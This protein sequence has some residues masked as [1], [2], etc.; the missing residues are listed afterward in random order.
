MEVVVSGN[1]RDTNRMQTPVQREY[2]A[3]AKFL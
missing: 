2:V 3:Y 1:S